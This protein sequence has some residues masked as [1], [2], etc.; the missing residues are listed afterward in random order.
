MI[1]FFIGLIIFTPSLSLIFHFFLAFYVL[2]HFK[3]QNK[4][5]WIS[6]IHDL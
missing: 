1:E 5:Y 3:K 2:I 6:M 4:S